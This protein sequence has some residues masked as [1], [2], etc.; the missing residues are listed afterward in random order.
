MTLILCVI[1][2]SSSLVHEYINFPDRFTSLGFIEFFF[3]VCTFMFLQ[4]VME[5]LKAALEEASA[6]SSL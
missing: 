5:D 6:V 3:S 2:L 1:K 4:L